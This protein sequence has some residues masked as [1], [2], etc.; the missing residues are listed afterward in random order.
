MHPGPIMSIRNTW[1]AEGSGTRGGFIALENPIRTGPSLPFTGE[2]IVPGK[3][4]EP[5]LREHE[6][7]YVFAGKFVKEKVVLDV[8]CGTGIGTQYLL[9]AGA[10]RC[11]GLDIDGA[12]VAYAKAAYEGCQFAQCDAMNLCVPDSSID[13]V[14]SF[15]TIE[16]LGDQ[17][18][19]LQECNRV[20]RSGGF[21]IC[22]TPNHAIHR[23]A[24]KN[25]FHVREFTVRQF[26]C[27]LESV[28]SDVQLYSQNNKIYL[29]HVAKTLLLPL[30][31]KLKLKNTIKRI[32]RPKPV[33][34][35]LGAE[36][37]GNPS[38][39]DNEIKL[40]AEGLFLKP[41]YV[42]AVARSGTGIDRG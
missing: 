37:D 13:V 8:A 26:T 35:P 6:E 10:Q 25:P 18:K 4:P 17:V 5:L 2:R 20:L 42:V 16:H 9:M 14:V 27:I 24:L 41:A 40:Y 33:S 31:A 23:W 22:S 19:F 3:T 34:I 7:R 1:S 32:L 28:F 11:L 39:A 30:L 21:L 36:F 15:E 29:L 38:N 12:A